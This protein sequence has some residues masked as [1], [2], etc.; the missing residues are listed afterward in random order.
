MPDLENHGA[1][2]IPTPPDCA[3]LSWIVNLLVKDVHLIEYLFRFF[4]T[5][6][7]FLF[8]IPAFLPIKVEAHG[9]YNCYTKLEMPLF[10]C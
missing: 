6:A 10:L 5:D 3:E 7:M 8:D 4:Q 1:Q 9:L 2:S